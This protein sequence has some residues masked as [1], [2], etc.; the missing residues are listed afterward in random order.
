MEPCGMEFGGTGAGCIATGA[1]GNSN[2]GPG[3]IDDAGDGIPPGGTT[4]A[5]ASANGCFIA[6]GMGASTGW[7]I[8]TWPL[9]ASI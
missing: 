6:S 7:A 9:C 8:G 3:G 2:G 5:R 4:R 1:V